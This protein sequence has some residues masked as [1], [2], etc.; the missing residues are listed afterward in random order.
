VARRARRIPLWTGRVLS[1][2]ARFHERREVTIIY[3][4]YMTRDRRPAHLDE[5]RRVASRK[6]RLCKAWWLRDEVFFRDYIENNTLRWILPSQG[7]VYC[8]ISTITW[9]YYYYY[10]TMLQAALVF[11]FWPPKNIFCSFVRKYILYELTLKPVTGPHTRAMAPK[12]TR[13]MCSIVCE[14]VTHI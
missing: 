7:R 9:L 5:P 12:N 14:S 4:L 2:Y 10:I 8:C 6:Y 3:I 13:R 1:I 11:F